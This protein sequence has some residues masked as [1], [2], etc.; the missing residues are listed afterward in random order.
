MAPEISVDE[1]REAVR[2]QLDAV[3]RRFGAS[4]QLGTDDYWGLFSPEMFVANDSKPELVG[5]SLSD[6][7]S[8]LRESLRNDDPSEDE[9]MLW[10]D[11]D[12]L[13]G[14]LQRISALATS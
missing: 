11:M 9:L 12:H 7:V 3:E 4:V 14:I 13:A 8:D 5:R 10:H 1:L 6:D 2:R